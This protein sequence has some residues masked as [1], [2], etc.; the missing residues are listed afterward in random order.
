MYGYTQTKMDNNRNPPRFRCVTHMK[1]NSKIAM[2]RTQHGMSEF[3]SRNYIEVQ[4]KS[5]RKKRSQRTRDISPQTK[6]MINTHSDN[7]SRT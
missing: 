6:L 5:Q 4:D 7:V 3:R 2:M 1:H